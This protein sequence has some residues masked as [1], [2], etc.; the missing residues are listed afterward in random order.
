M[1]T[2]QRYIQILKHK[3]KAESFSKGSRRILDYTNKNYN[4]LNY[5][6]KAQQE[7]I[8]NYVIF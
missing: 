3:S 4:S 7:V 6:G 1:R 5:T 2:N 8:K